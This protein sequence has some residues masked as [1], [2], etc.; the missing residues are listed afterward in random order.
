VK[1]D[2]KIDSALGARIKKVR[3]TR[4]DLTQQQFADRLSGVT[5]GAVGNWERGLGIKRENLSAIAKEFDVSFEWL[6]ENRGLM[7]VETEPSNAL[8]G[9]KLHGR[10]NT[11]PLYGHAVG[12]Q[13]GEFVLNGNKLDDITAPPSLSAAKGAY[14]VTVAGESMSPRYEDG[15]TVYVDPT[16]RVVRGNYV[17]AQI[18]HEEA[19]A[20]LAYIKRFVR[21]NAD[22][23]VLEQ[24][25]PPKELRFKHQDVATV[26]YIVMGGRVT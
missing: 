9:D 20:L 5:R 11:I 3:Q 8:V 6:A 23:L 15:E 7:D 14:A 13:D 21:H 12:G 26:H 24:L 19:G 16:R 10:V 17:V 1:N 25:N 4:G 18:Q 2:S 22:E